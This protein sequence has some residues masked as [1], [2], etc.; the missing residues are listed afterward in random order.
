MTLRVLFISLSQKV[1]I[2]ILA[3]TPAEAREIGVKHRSTLAYLNKKARKGDLN[4]KSKNVK[5]IVD[6]YNH[7]SFLQSHFHKNSY[8]LLCSGDG[9]T[10]YSQF[11]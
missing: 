5:R 1:K 4:F 8:Y 9:Y 7:F 3:L 10:Y 11:Y 6:N 2:I